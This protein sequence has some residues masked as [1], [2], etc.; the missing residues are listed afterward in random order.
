MR[1]YLAEAYKDRTSTLIN[2]D[3]RLPRVVMWW[4]WSGVRIPA[5]LATVPV[6]PAPLHNYSVSSL[7]AVTI[8]TDENATDP[9]QASK[10]EN[11]GW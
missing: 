6:G 10:T 5:D 7:D 9:G 1:V 8:D 11:T 4:C 3:S 2:T